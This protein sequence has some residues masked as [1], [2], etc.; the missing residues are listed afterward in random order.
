MKIC[1]ERKNFFGY[2]LSQ[3]TGA[4]TT[5][6]LGL[7]HD[8]DFHWFGCGANEHSQKTCTGHP[9]TPKSPFQLFVE[10]VL[11]ENDNSRCDTTV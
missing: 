5:G 3:E 10:Q 8:R 6:A 7:D 4:C 1:Q 9:Y 2:P 11:D